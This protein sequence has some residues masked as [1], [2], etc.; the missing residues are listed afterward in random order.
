L[1]EVPFFD[2]VLRFVEGHVRGPR[3][4]AALRWC[5][6][7]PPVKSLQTVPAP[8]SPRNVRQPVW[9]AGSQKKRGFI[10]LC[11]RLKRRA[12]ARVVFTAR[13][14][15]FSALLCKTGTANSELDLE[16]PYLWGGNVPVIPAVQGV[17]SA[18]VGARVFL[19][20][21]LVAAPQ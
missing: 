8:L 6:D 5:Y 13:G 17:P 7:T 9:R 12:S 14:R 3:F 20:A 15:G 18:C 1:T 11:P 10:R 21:A 4:L 2:E 16:I 19:D